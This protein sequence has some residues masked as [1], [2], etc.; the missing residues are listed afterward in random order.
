MIEKLRPKNLLLGTFRCKPIENVKANDRSYISEIH[1]IY[2]ESVDIFNKIA[3]CSVIILSRERIQEEIDSIW[4]KVLSETFKKEVKT[5]IYNEGG[6]IECFDSLLLIEENC[7]ENESFYNIR[8]KNAKSGW[9][10]LEQEYSI[11]MS[12]IVPK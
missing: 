7:I 6:I 8:S 9:Q 5:V 12:E 3:Y 4:S 10:Y 2:V 11:G 1:V